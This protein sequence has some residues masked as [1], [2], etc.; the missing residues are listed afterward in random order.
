MAAVGVGLGAFFAPYRAVRG[1]NPAAGA[2]KTNPPASEEA[3]RAL[4][5]KLQV[6]SDSQAKLPKDLKPVVITEV[7]ANSY[8][9][10][11]GQGFLPPG[12]SNPEVHINPGQ[13][14]ATASV[15][16]SQL[17]QTV[18]KADDWQGKTLSW[19]FKEKQRVSA[20]GK[21]ETGNGQGTLKITS[22]MVGNVQLP[23]WM[24]DW[25][26]Q[27]YV[28]SRSSVDL[29]KPFTLPDHVTHIVLAPGQATFYRSPDKQR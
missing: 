23:D 17:N 11:R 6:L 10:S 20:T 1:D 19:L 12:V 27:N 25:A 3:A 16:L 22:I 28:N 21:L 29:T 4:E 9:K 18:A 14:S 13:V 2:D 15:D 26:L 5:A 7:E 8:L 24:V